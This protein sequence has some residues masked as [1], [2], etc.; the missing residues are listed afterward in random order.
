MEVKNTKPEM[1]LIH[2]EWMQNP[3]YIRRISHKKFIGDPLCGC[4]SLGV[5]QIIQSIRKIV[6]IKKQKEHNFNVALENY[7]QMQR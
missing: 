1:K 3:K 5:F 2:L 6:A 4:N 7:L